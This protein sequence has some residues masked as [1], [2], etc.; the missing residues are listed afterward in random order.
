MTPRGNNSVKSQLTNMGVTIH[1]RGK[2]KSPNLIN[3][4]VSEIEDICLSNN[5]HYR[6]LGD[7]KQRITELSE[8]AGHK[9]KLLDK[10]LNLNIDGISFK[11]HEDAENMQF[12]FDKEGALKS[13]FATMLGMNEGKKLEWIFCKTQFAG[14]DIHI[15]LINLL[16]YLQK[17]YFKKLEITD[18]GGYYPDKDIDALNTRMGFIDNALS[19]VKEIFE[20]SEFD[21]KSPDQVMDQIQD[22]LTRSLKGIKV[23]IVKIDAEELFSKGFKKKEDDTD[24]K[25]EKKRKSRRKKKDD[26][27]TDND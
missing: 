7:E 11:P 10:I 26:E 18:E 27:W 19:T 13:V 17:K 1:Y 8:K 20:Q 3:D 24:D 15:K 21:G 12:I 22:A 9:G 14:A 4:V 23:H 2:L 25:D 16:I 6:I 5:W